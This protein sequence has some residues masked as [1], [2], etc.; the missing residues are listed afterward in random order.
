MNGIKPTHPVY[1]FYNNHDETDDESD[2]EESVSSWSDDESEPVSDTDSSWPETIEEVDS[3]SEDE[4]M[5]EVTETILYW[6]SMPEPQTM[7]SVERRRPPERT[8]AEA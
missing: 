4:T 3:D 7:S 2:D 5:D 1:V 6:E 8:C